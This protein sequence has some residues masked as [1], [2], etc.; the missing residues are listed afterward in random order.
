MTGAFRSS[1][2]IVRYRDLGAELV[3]WLVG[4]SETL[5]GLQS[6]TGLETDLEGYHLAE[7]AVIRVDPM[8][9]QEVLLQSLA[10]NGRALNLEK[11]FRLCSMEL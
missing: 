2:C 6:T 3:Y 5:V 9:L 1:Y 4:G 10:L 8:F 7:D 11:G